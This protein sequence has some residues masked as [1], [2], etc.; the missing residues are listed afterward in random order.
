MNRDHKYFHALGIRSGRIARVG[1][2][3]LCIAV[4]ACGLTHDDDARGSA[5]ADSSIA[6]TLADAFR[7]DS[8][9]R[10]FQIVGGF[11]LADSVFVALNGQKEIRVHD[12]TGKL[13]RTI[14]RAGRGPGEFSS[15]AWMQRGDAAALLILDHDREALIGG[16]LTRDPSRRMTAV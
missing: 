9:D 3:V 12:A 5:M 13:I 10:P 6:D 8:L 15:V 2:A 16:A 11:F 1:R 7:S 4:S 14:G